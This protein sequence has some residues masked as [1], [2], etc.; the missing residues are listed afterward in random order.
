[1]GNGTWTDPN[2]M[3]DMVSVAVVPPRSSRQ[4]TDSI[5]WSV[6]S[7]IIST[8]VYSGRSLMN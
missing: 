8:L 4:T 6:G 2:A 7:P 1:M 5:S 3:G